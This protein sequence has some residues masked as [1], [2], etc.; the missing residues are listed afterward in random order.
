MTKALRY[1]WNAIVIIAV[2]YTLLII[3][4]LTPIFHDVE[5]NDY[6]E[7][8]F[9]TVFSL[10]VYGVNAWYLNPVGYIEINKKAVTLHKIHGATL[11]IAGMLVWLHF[12]EFSPFG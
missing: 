10:I 3:F 1:T 4:K 6:L 11:F 7:A 5:T 9:V 8:Y 2:S 12:Q